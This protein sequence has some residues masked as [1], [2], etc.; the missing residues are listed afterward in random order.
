MYPQHMQR[1]Q[2]FAAQALLLR[3]KSIFSTRSTL[4]NHDIVL[5]MNKSR[6]PPSAER[7]KAPIRLPSLAILVRSEGQKPELRGNWA[8]KKHVSK[9]KDRD[10]PYKPLT[11]KTNKVGIYLCNAYAYALFGSLRESPRNSYG[12]T[13]TLASL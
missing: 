8:P 12:W 13:L 9:N 1:P 3:D 6:F 10:V 7:S 11:M 4:K 5:T 2:Q